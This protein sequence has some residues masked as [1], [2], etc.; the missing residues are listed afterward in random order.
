MSELC[1]ICYEPLDK[2]HT[3]KLKCGHEFHYECL[4]QSFKRDWL[5]SCPYCRSENNSLPLVNGLKKIDYNIHSGYIDSQYENHPCCHILQKGK[6]K[7][8]ACNKN[9]L[10]GELFC[11]AHSKK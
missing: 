10:L 8:Y 7:G 6:R 3:H 9:C 11:R 4:Y 5:K 2:K 1:A